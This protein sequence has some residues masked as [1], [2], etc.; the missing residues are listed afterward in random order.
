MTHIGI[1]RGENG[2]IGIIP[3]EG[4]PIFVDVPLTKR[5]YTKVKLD[6]KKFIELMKPYAAI[7]INE[8]Q[9]KVVAKAV[10]EEAL[11][12]KNK[13][14]ASVT[15][16]RI[17]ESVV[18]ILDALGISVQ[19]VQPTKWHYQLFIGKYRKCSAK[20]ASIDYAA[21][22]FPQFI[23]KHQHDRFGICLADWLARG[24]QH[25]WTSRHFY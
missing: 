13:F 9:S 15:Q 21:E 25:E 18:G 19:T 20:Q 7:P 5:S 3:D 10:V 6:Y 4:E 2:T 14:K 1:T 22:L 17:F 12:D 8:A 24:I 11:Y 16:A 23:Q